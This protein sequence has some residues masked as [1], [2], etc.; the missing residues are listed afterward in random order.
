MIIDNK[1]IIA[2]DYILLDWNV[3]QNIKNQ[4]RLSDDC[5]HII[6]QIRKRYEFPFCE[7]HLKDL[8][9]SIAK[10]SQEEI[11][12]DLL[13]LQQ[14]SNKVAIGI[15]EKFDNFYL[16][17]SEPK[18]LFEEIIND[19]SINYNSSTPV[20]PQSVFS[21]D[22]KAL[23]PKHPMRNLLEKSDGTYT[24][25]LMSNWLNDLSSNLFDDIDSYKNIR[26]YVTKLKQ[27]LGQNNYQ[28]NLSSSDIAY[29]KELI[30]CATPF[31]DSLQIDKEEE[32]VMIWKK[33]IIS[34]L[35][36]N[37]QAEPSFGMQIT[38]AYN[39]LDLHPLF[40]DKLKKGKNTLNNITRDSKMIYFASK[41][42]YFV[43]ED[44]RCLKK[45]NFIFKA[46]GFNCKAID[47]QQFVTKFN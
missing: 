43:T 21:I 4:I 37:H 33:V 27:D 40:R 44:K 31:L 5:T 23:N 2:K 10:S 8:A 26:E 19:N 3:I 18:K 46:Y 7:A 42:K 25:E 34:W 22:M 24:P 41:G 6:N 15:D 28:D 38:T 45:A 35:Q 16:I 29:G 11:D 30:N 20:Y 12:N 32:L 39:M 14:L 36:I 47:M 17:I 13:F 9:N 1:D